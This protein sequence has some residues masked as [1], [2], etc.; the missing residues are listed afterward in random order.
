MALFTA[1]FVPTLTS[2]AAGIKPETW[3]IMTDDGEAAAD[4]VLQRATSHAARTLG[5]ADAVYA[6]PA[7]AAP[8]LPEVELFSTGFDETPVGIVTWVEMPAQD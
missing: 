6:P 3:L 1:M 7:D 2:L 5:H 4:Q 8:G